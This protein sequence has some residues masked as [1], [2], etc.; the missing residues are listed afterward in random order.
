MTNRLIAPNLQ[1]CDQNGSPY[2]G[3][4][5][6][7][8]QSGTSTPLAVFSDKALSISR[9]TVVALDS[10]GRAGD[11]FLQNVAYKVV[12]ADINSVQIWTADPVY[13]SDFSALAQVQATNGSP[14]GQLAGAAGSIGIPAS[15]AWDFVG[16]ILYVCTTTGSAASAAWTAVNAASAA[17]IVPPPQGYLTPTSQTPII[18][19]DVISATSLF[20]TPYVG[21]IVPIFNGASFVPTAFSEL[22]LNLTAGAHAANGI[23]D[24][25]V[26]NNTGV[27]TIATGPAW[28]NSGAGT[29]ARGTGAGTTQL[30]RVSGIWTNSV[31]ISGAKNGASSFNIGAGLGTC[32]G[33][34][35]ID[36]V[37]GQVT[38]HR[39]A[40]QSRKWSAWNFYNR[41]PIY[42]RVLDP[43]AS[44]TYASAT[45]RASNGNNANSL[46]AFAGLAEEAVTLD[47]SQSVSQQCQIGNPN[48]FTIINGSAV[49]GIGANSTTVSSFKNGAI[50]ITQNA[51]FAGNSVGLTETFENDL[52]AF[53]L[54]LPSLGINTFTCLEA[55]TANAVTTTF[56]GGTAGMIMTGSWRG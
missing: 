48:G 10:A 20:Y 33:S 50:S 39:T 9:G 16:Q 22:T 13:A 40:A 43:T 21:N 29:G 24:V 45:V 30:S 14:N 44:W 23:Y 51:G 38:F 4:S 41:A 42:L 5:L 35:F 2:A 47:F 12:L 17:A 36:S 8:F 27:V 31:A 49:T 25:F 55:T 15:M 1:F 37:A 32:V 53:G 28:S 3:G 54:Q 46:T 7:F 11:V 52:K 6:S 19:G 18:P 34:I 26:F 56:F